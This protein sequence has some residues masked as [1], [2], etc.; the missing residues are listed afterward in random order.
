MAAQGL[1]GRNFEETQF[2]N[3]GVLCRNF[4]ETSLKTVDFPQDELFESQKS[5]FFQ[6]F[7]IFCF[8]NWLY[9]DGS[10]GPIWL[11]L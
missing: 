9:H 7:S 8:Y 11:E 2:L 4:Q 3:R 5:K 1:G 10:T 6:F